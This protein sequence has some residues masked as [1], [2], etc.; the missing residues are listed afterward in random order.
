MNGISCLFNIDNMYFDEDKTLNKNHLD[1]AFR[2]L[3]EGSEVTY[4]CFKRVTTKFEIRFMIKS[5]HYAY[6]CPKE[7]IY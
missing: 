7:I 1:L 6:L 3:F 5:R 4:H 2:E